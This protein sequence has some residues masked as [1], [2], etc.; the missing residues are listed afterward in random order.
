MYQWN[1]SK[2]YTSLE[3][4]AFTEDL[5]R[6]DEINQRWAHFTATL[7]SEGS[8]E[9]LK[10]MLAIQTE[11]Y[12]VAM[13]LMDYLSLSSSVDSTNAKV[14][15]LLGVVSKKLSDSAKSDAI[16]EKYIA[17]I[18]DLE[19]M[20]DSDHELVPYKEYLLQTKKWN[21]Y[22]LSDEVEEVISKLSI[23]STEAWSNLQS[24]LTSTMDVDY[25]GEK[26]TLSQ[27]RNMAYD[28]SPEV[29][30]SAYEAELAAYSHVKDAVAFSLNSLKG[31]VNTICEMRGF[32]SALERTLI[33]SRMSQETLDALLDAIKEYLP[34]FHMYLRRKGELLGHENGLPWYDLFAPMGKSNERKYTVEESKD[35]LLDGFKDFDGELCDMIEK[36]YEE[37]W[38]DFLPKRGKVGGAFCASNSE[39]KQSFILTNYDGSLSDIVTL[40]HELG[41]AFHSQQV[42][43]EPTINLGYSMPLAE[44][45]STFNEVVIMNQ[46]IKTCE[47]KDVKLK[48]IESTLQDV[49]QIICDIYSRYL[50]ESNVFEQRKSAFLYA[51]E[52][53][54]IMRNAQLSAYGDGLDPNCLH[55]YMWVCKGHYYSAG[56]SYYNF[57]YAFGG[58]FAR[59]LYAVYQREGASFVAK[60]KELLKATVYKDAEE[61]ARLADIDITQKE[62]WCSALDSVVTMI[63]EFMELTK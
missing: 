36:A 28:E 35:Y 11:Q 60:Y 45:A 55:P 5:N 56:L 33:Y 25:K 10:Q 51:D 54:E 37:E 49:T 30:K 44:T 12:Q 16:S 1:L 3:D 2:L 18:A 53:E 21:Q 8:A 23:D 50:F 57:P 41:H 61:V 7:S 15:S 43:D 9:E 13:R 63:D 20:I 40:G 46:M 4:P 59:G 14:Q 62:F 22:S 34:K 32:E 6:L 58:L 29:R 24:Y 31:H 19:A 42:Q 27:I 48:L 26:V 47:E 39:L 52:L 38:I 17:K